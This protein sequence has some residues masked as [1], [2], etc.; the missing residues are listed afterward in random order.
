M[1]KILF[2]QSE[3]RGAAVHYYLVV[4]EA[5]GIERYGLQVCY[6]DETETVLDITSSQGHI[7]ALLEAM[8]RGSVTPATAREVVDDWLNGWEA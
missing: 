3:C 1:R 4:E 8:A 2:S 5:V 7:Q 6:G